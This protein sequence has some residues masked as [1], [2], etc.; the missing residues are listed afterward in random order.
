MPRKDVLHDA[1]RRALVKDGWIITDDP[2]RIEFGGQELFVDLGAEELIGAE[3]G[4]REI[5]VEVKSFMAASALNEFHTAV[6]QFVN[7]RM[8]LAESQ[9]RRTLYLAVPEGIYHS[10]L[11]TVFGRLAI[12]V[13]QLKVAVVDERQEVIVRWIE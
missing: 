1:A 4:G 3:K 13:H 9:P 5:A 7:Y 2:L 11:D 6:G 12:Q 8:V 10:L